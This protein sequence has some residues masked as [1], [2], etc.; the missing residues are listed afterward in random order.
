MSARDPKYPTYPKLWDGPSP[1][2]ES[3]TRYMA[4]LDMPYMTK[5][6]PDFVA[7][8]KGQFYE[9]NSTQQEMADTSFIRAADCMPSTSN[10]E[11]I[12]DASTRSDGSLRITRD[13]QG[14]LKVKRSSRAFLPLLDWVSPDEKDVVM[15]VGPGRYTPYRK[16]KDLA[17]PSESDTT[18]FWS[19]ATY[20]PG[21]QFGPGLKGLFTRDAYPFRRA[22]WVNGIKQDVNRMVVGAAIYKEPVGGGNFARYL[23]VVLLGVSPFLDLWI[24]DGR[25]TEDISHYVDGVMAIALDKFGTTVGHFDLQTDFINSLKPEDRGGR[26][27]SWGHIKSGKYGTAAPFLFNA[28]ATEAMCQAA[29]ETFG[30]FGNIVLS[31]PGLGRPTWALRHPYVK[32]DTN[33]TFTGDPLDGANVPIGGNGSWTA[34][35]TYSGEKFPLAADYLWGTDTVVTL[36]RELVSDEKTTTAVYTKNVDGQGNKTETSNVTNSA[37]SSHK[38]T[39]GGVELAAGSSSSGGTASVTNV[40]AGPSSSST[41]TRQAAGAAD[42]YY[43]CYADDLRFGLV[44]LRRSSTSGGVDETRVRT[45]ASADWSEG[46]YALGSGPGY[47]YGTDGTDELRFYVR[48]PTNNMGEGSISLLANI[49]AD[50]ALYVH[51]SEIVYS[52][53]LNTVLISMYT[54]DSKDYALSPG[55]GGV[56]PLYSYGMKLAGHGI[57]AFS[58][59]VSG[60]GGALSYSYAPLAHGFAA[61]QVLMCLSAPRSASIGGPA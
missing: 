29:P 31:W 61:D 59:T 8:K 35:S 60:S 26:P 27:D 51:K 15:W 36:Q 25:V 4:G 17:F 56:L 38:F 13:R 21:I 7:R 44:H 32:G 58:R 10:Q 33:N 18:R 23:K 1:V 6:G 30:D 34:T 50:Q 40:T 39:L 5:V 53:R 12:G 48:L 3:Q 57:F 2:G 22:V 41:L 20:L 37:Q 19:D 47:A 24:G 9:V 28:S 11:G 16:V 55:A 43:E 45:P 52:T 46:Y 42:T 54:Y 14:N 49:P